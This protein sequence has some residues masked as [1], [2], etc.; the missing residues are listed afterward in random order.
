MPA[1]LSRDEV[2]RIAALARLALTEEE[3]DLFSRQLTHI[4]EY[5]AHISEVD[6][7]GVPPTAHVLTRATTLRAD[8]VRESLPRDEALA[9]APDVDRAAGLFRVPRVLA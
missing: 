9:N 1:E 8:V 4:L 7:A 3:V 6:T 5:V 2:L